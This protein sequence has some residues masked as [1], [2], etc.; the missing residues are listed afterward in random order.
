MGVTRSGL[1][2]ENLETANKGKAPAATL[3]IALEAT[4]IPQKK[5]MEEEAEALMMIIKASEYKV[6]E[7]MGKSPTHI[8]LLALLLGSEPHREALL[9]VLTVVYGPECRLSSRLAC[10]LL[11][12]AARDHP[13]SVGRVMGRCEKEA[14]L[15]ILRPE[16]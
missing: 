16:G 8:S 4:P 12:R 1:V 3:G 14:P 13:P 7:Q 6:V 10:A 11:D 2:Y 9:K 15:I 5:V